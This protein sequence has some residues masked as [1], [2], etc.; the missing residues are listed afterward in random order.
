MVGCDDYGDDHDGLRLSLIQG[1]GGKEV[2]TR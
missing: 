2:I 1:E